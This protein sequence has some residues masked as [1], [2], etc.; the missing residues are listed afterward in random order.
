MGIRIFTILNSVLI[1]LY[2]IGAYFVIPPF[3]DLFAAFDAQLPLLT[4]LMIHSY[5]YW[6]FLLVIPVV[7]FFEYIYNKE[8]SDAVNKTASIISITLFAFLVLLLPLIVAAMFLPV[9]Y[10]GRGC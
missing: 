6:I 8:G 7:V 10:V 3:V 1:L 9:F 4:K 2:S 5:P